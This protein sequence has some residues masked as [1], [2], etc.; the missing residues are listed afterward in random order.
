MQRTCEEIA[1]DTVKVAKVLKRL[2]CLQLGEI[3]KATELTRWQVRF[4][5]AEL[6]R[7]KRVVLI[8]DKAR[9]VY[10]WVGG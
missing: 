1:R 10:K 9:A 2:E 3:E 7:T 5:L 4:A 8:G 6:R